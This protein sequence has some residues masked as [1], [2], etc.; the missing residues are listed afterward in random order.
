MS[1]EQLRLD[2]GADEVL[3]GG[4]ARRGDPPA[5]DGQPWALSP[6]AKRPSQ[7]PLRRIFGPGPEGATC[8]G[9]IHLWRHGGHANSYLK[10]D[11]RQLTHGP[12]SDH[13][14]GWLACGRYEEEPEQLQVE[15]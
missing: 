3:Q 4:Q 6:H 15:P 11:L 12:G 1:L 2:G 8:R 5:D 10:C 9:C 14:A 7:N 13:R